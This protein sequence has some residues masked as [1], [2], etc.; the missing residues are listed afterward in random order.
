M[1][2]QVVDRLM[3]DISLMNQQH[4]ILLN[5][6]LIGASSTMRRQLLHHFLMHLKVFKVSDIDIMVCLFSPFAGHKNISLKALAGPK[7]KTFL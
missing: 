3:F 2:F 6:R 1:S 4:W 7:G 5:T